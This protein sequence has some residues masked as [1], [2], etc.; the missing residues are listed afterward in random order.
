LFDYALLN[1]KMVALVSLY[2]F[3]EYG[4]YLAEA[5]RKRE[6]SAGIVCGDSS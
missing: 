5:S 2:D 6:N 1:G 4:N 3:S